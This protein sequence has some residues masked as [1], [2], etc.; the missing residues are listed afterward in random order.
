M[1]GLQLRLGLGLRP[2]SPS[3]GG[4][5]PAPYPPI[6]GFHWEY[7]TSSGAPVTSSGAPVVALVRN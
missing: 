5:V 7:V 3:T 4:G 2:R 1:P 6:D